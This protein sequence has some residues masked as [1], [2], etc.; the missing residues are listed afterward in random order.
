VLVREGILY[1]N[2]DLCRDLSDNSLTGVIPSTA[3]RPRRLKELSVARNKL[4]G[5]IPP[6]LSN[7][8][9]LEHL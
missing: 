9:S 3:D 1:S 7:I 5:A 8:L 2:D 6:T 4:T